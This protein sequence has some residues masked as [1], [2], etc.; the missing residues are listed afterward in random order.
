MNLPPFLTNLPAIDLPFP[1][2]VVRTSAIRSD[3]GLMVIFEILQDFELPPHSHKAQWGTVLAGEVILTIAGDTK[4]YTPGMS[5]DIPSGAEH[6]AFVRAGT[7]VM[8]IFEE[9]DRYAVKK[10]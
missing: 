3:D 9:P 5:Y 2:D 8:D 7:I 1:E 6:S 10:S 4:T